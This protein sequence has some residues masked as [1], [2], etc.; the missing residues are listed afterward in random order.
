MSLRDGSVGQGPRACTALQANRRARTRQRREP[1]PEEGDARPVAT[2]TA[3]AAPAAPVQ[4]DGVYPDPP[5]VTFLQDG[6]IS[7]FNPVVTWHWQG[8]AVEARLLECPFRY[9]G[10]K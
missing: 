4:P 1:P 2:E 3:E 8:Q 6:D 7:Q 5:Y 9:N 10:Y